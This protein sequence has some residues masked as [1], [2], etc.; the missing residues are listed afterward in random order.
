MW[1]AGLTRETISE[2]VIIHVRDSDDWTWVAAVV[3]SLN[4]RHI[5]QIEPRESAV[6][7]GEKK[8]KNQKYF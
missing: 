1:T 6:E 2:N 4:S 7:L 3:E 8:P 5:L